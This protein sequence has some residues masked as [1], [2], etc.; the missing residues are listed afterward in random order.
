V[1]EAISATLTLALGVAISPVPI[2]ATILMLLSPTAS[3]TGTSFLLGWLVGIT[4]A[5]SVF[6]AL[7]ALMPTEQGDKGSQPVVAAIQALLPA[8]DGVSDRTKSHLTPPRARAR[9]SYAS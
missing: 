3:R 8:S 1:N 4:G 9:H 2:I 7:G 5:V 6:T